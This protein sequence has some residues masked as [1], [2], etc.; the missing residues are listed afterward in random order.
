M[1]RKI[2]SL[3]AARMVPC[4]ENTPPIRHERPSAENVRALATGTAL[5]VSIDTTPAAVV[6]IY[7]YAHR[8]RD[9]PRRT[10]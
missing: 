10:A 2:M 3:A 6:S 4:N 5:A 8:F 9:R 1:L 7:E